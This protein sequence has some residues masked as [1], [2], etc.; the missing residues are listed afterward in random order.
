MKQIAAAFIKAWNEFEE[1]KRTTQGYGYKYAPM[2][3]IIRATKPALVKNGLAIIQTP[4]SD[5]DKVGIKTSM[6]HES[7]EAFTES[8]YADPVKND[9]QS[10]GSLFTYLRRYAYMAFCQLAPEDDDGHSAMPSQNAGRVSA[11]KKELKNTADYMVQFGKFKGLKLSE[12]QSS[13]LTNYV[14]YL[15]SQAKKENKPMRT[16]VID[17]ISNVEAHLG[18]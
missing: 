15:E 13:D 12:I 16:Q 14:D 2:D 7:G 3:E 8:F 17:F 4:I 11:P 1:P 10:L 5:G 18:V 6:I 9:P